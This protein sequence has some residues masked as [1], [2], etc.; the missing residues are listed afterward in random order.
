[1]SKKGGQAPGDKGHVQE[2]GGRTLQVKGSGHSPGLA[3]ATGLPDLSALK[4]LSSHFSRKTPNP[5]IK[6]L[7]GCLG[8]LQKMW[9]EVSYTS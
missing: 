1:M 9:Q 8:S 6:E 3:K 7:T 4:D 2:E 5:G